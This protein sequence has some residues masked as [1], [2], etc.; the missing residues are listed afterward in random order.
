M[1]TEG[2]IFT[3]KG[4]EL[5]K[6]ALAEEKILNFTKFKIGTGDKGTEDEYLLLTDIVSPY[7]ILD[8]SLL[9]KTES[10]L[11]KASTV[12]TNK[13]FISDVIIKE[14]GLFAKIAEEEEI[15]LMYVNDGYGELFPAGNSGNIV[16][17][18]RSFEF[19]I[20]G[21]TNVQAIV[22]ETMFAN[23]YQLEE[24][25]DKT[26][27]ISTGTGLSG[28]GDLTKDLKIVVLPA[29]KTTL[30]GVIAGDNVTIDVKGK[31]N[32]PAQ[33]IHPVGNGNNH[34]PLGGKLKEFLRWTAAGVASWGRILS[35][36]IELTSTQR[37]VTDVE[38]ANWNGKEP[39]FAKNSGHNKNF[40]V[41][42]NEVMPGELFPAELGTDYAG[43][44]N[45]TG[46]KY[47]GKT[48]FCTATKKIYLC[49]IQ[50]SL[51]YADLEKFVDISHKGLL[52]KLENLFRVEILQTNIY[53][54]RIAHNGFV[55]TTS[56]DL[57]S[58]NK[59]EFRFVTIGSDSV[60]STGIITSPYSTDKFSFSVTGSQSSERRV[61]TVSFSYSRTT[62]TLTLLQGAEAPQVHLISIYGYRNI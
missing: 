50:N 27:K 62:K 2:V 14:V 19:G 26:R 22:N 46:V 37:F 51:T 15:L 13:D 5:L 58:Y 24:K 40:G 35:S 53:L 54:G 59:L 61:F 8:I 4:L 20:D 55:C 11:I 1:K 7:K 56:S 52:D 44:L 36:D 30:G 39:S 16:Q 10:G 49:K 48:Y 18:S 9:K 57:L 17:R 12:F 41:N 45:V 34:I 42:K 21:N 6:R 60:L 33:Y 47:I 23:I 31:I 3:N 25:V 28:G 32:V 43:I 38:K 29:T